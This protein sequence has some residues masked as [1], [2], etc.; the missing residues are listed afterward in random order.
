MPTPLN[1]KTYSLLEA[2]VDIAMIVQWAIEENKWTPP[3]DSR[4]CVSMVISAA[5]EFEEKNA[6]RV[7]DG[8]YLEEIEHFTLRKLDILL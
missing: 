1:P 7:W 5:Q 8:E 4:D 2:A 3:Q 6:D